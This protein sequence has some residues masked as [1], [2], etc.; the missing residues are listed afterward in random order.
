ML[1]QPEFYGGPFFNLYFTDDPVNGRIYNGFRI[2]LQDQDLRYCLGKDE[3]FKMWWLGSNEVMVQIPSGSFTFF[4]DAQAEQKGK[5]KAGDIN[6]RISQATNI[7]R[8]SIKNSENQDRLFKRYLLQL[9]TLEEHDQ[10]D[11]TVYSPGSENGKVK[12]K[13]VVLESEFEVP[14][15]D[16]TGNIT[17]KKVTTVRCDVYW[18]IAIWEPTHRAETVA[19]A[20]TNEQMDQLADQ[21][22]GM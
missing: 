15:K 9:P 18:N 12:S 3:V 1:S 14:K 22:A 2:M 8:N 5:T 4:H 21:F 17:Y 13:I 10:F 11:N 7:C 6:P 19:K 16:S 20:T